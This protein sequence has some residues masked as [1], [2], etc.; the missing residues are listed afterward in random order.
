MG[1]CGFT[2]NYSAG[3]T[4]A[5]FANVYA[6]AFFNSSLACFVLCARIERVALLCMLI[7]QGPEVCN[8]ARETLQERPMECDSGA[9]C[10]CEHATLHPCTCQVVL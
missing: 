6:S 5:G 8:I 3:F 2:D 1:P 10:S 9:V 4:F 7:D